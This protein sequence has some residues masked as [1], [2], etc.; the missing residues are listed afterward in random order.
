[1]TLQSEI[2]NVV[3][4]VLAFIC[5]STA[6]F[7]ENPSLPIGLEAIGTPSNDPLLPMGLGLVGDIDEVKEDNR[8]PKGWR[9]A[10][11]FEVTGFF[12]TRLGAR[13]Q[14]D[15]EQKQLSIGEAR[16]HLKAS[17]SWDALTLNFTSDFLYD[18][19]AANHTVDVK[20]GEGW[21]DIREANFVAQPFSFMDIKAGR[22]ILTWGTGDLLFIN[23]M[24]PKD[25]NSFFIGRDV[26]YL[27]APS[28]ALK[29]GLFSEQ[30]NLD[31][32]YTPRFDSD[33][34][35]DGR[36]ISYYNTSTGKMTGRTAPVRATTPDDY[37]EDAELSLRAHRLIGPVEVA[38]YFYDGFWKSPNG[39]NPSTGAFTFPE[40]NVYGASLRGPL[41]DGIANLEVGYYDSR[42]D[43]TG[44]N[45]Y[46]ANSEWRVMTGYEQEIAKDLTGG[47]QYY[48]EI[49]QNF[50]AY[51]TALPPGAKA[52]DEIRHVVTLRLT[53]MMMNQNLTLS[54]FNFYS[55]SDQDGYMRAKASYKLND[56]W[57]LEAG[58][59]AFYGKKQD[60]FFGQFEEASNIY[61][62]AR[63]G[64]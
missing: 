41:A 43:E 47:I 29:V 32:I 58:G 15:D 9:E 37:F 26:E 62:S 27:K 31:V 8:S 52:D 25:W 5:F 61:V 60:S 57:T 63:F 21:L 48:V 12:E 1:M 53:Q 2:K 59:N 28:D 17:K 38:F 51:K 34:Y 11:P 35:I 6:A 55:P 42:E 39:Q 36:R 13:L 16:L 56:S 24:F 7:A 44:T 54:A 23:D 22:Q 3:W 45:A 14:K 19:I 18:L 10:L 33:R 30:I 4:G 64:F 20:T 40:L 49:K 46:V 50:D